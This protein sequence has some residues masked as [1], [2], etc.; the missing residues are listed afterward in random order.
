MALRRKGQVRIIEATLAVFMTVALILMVMGFTRPFRSPYIRETGDL[1]RLAY[2]VLNTMAQ[3]NTFEV[4]LAERIWAV[5]DSKG[6]WR[7]ADNN[8]RE[9]ELFLALSMPPGILYKMDVFLINIS[10]GATQLVYLGSAANYDTTSVTLTEA[11]P[12][13]FTYTITGS[14]NTYYKDSFEYTSLPRFISSIVY[15]HPNTGV[16]LDSTS[17]PHIPPSLRTQVDARGD[18]LY[19]IAVGVYDLYYTFGFVPAAGFTFNVNGSYTRDSI[20]QLNNLAY[21]SVGVDTNWD[22]S[23]DEEHIFY[24][25]D[26][27]ATENPGKI[28]SV[29]LSLGS[30][31]CS[32]GNDGS[33]NPSNPSYKVYSLGTMTSGKTYTWAGALPST[34]GRVLRIAFAVVDARMSDSSGIR[35]DFWVNWDEVSLAWSYENLRGSVLQVLLTIG[36]AG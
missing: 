6:R 30:E 16:T 19:G 18:S 9:L 24:R 10:G 22:G 26:V 32:V 11:E 1:R 4:T 27:A 2:N 21:V 5:L 14:K 28:V 17:S 12:V 33:C 15:G 23:I 36:F 35:G 34:S 3:A 8:L 31:I 13:T 7:S 25:F 29:F 20:D